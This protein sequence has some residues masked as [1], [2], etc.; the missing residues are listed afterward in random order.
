MPA[1]R[2]LPGATRH[3]EKIMQS[4]ACAVPVG[5]TPILDRLE[6]QRAIKL[7]KD[8]FEVELARELNLQRVTAPLFV[9]A[10]S[11]LNDNLNGVERPIAFTA[12]ALGSARLEI[13][14]SLAKWKRLV[15]AELGL[16]PGEGI[17]TDMNAIRPDEQLD[18]LHSLYVDQWDWERVIQ[19]S[20]R[21]LEF[22]QTIVRRLYAAVRRTEQQVRQS[23]PQLPQ[24][25]VEEIT[26][27][28]AEELAA[29]YPGL[30]PRQREE[31]IV[32]QHKAVFVIGIGAPLA[33]GTPHDGRAPDY[34][35][36]ITPTDRG[37]GLNGDLLVLHPALGC[38]VELSSMGIRVTPETLAAQLALRGCEHR[39]HLPF[40]RRLLA[41]ELPPSI[42]GGLGQSRLAMVLLHKVHIGEVQCSLWPSKLRRLY[43]AAGVPL[44][45]A[46]AAPLG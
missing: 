16:P 32:R 18:A 38:A 26:F 3:G 39:R 8:C 40:H 46:E 5:Y 9:G 13:V 21:T 25:L 43:R 27:V 29:R 20:D 1:D 22:L 42:G 15:L 41:G 23:F 33:D 4:A 28:H 2:P 45:E 44:F 24:V 14:Q 37:R 35:D 17:Y 7:V 6:T 36:W 31:R 19:D 30:S 12:P 11:G 34:D 10:D